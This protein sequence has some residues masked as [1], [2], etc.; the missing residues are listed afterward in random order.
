[1]SQYL[2]SLA[3]MVAL[4]FLTPIAGMASADGFNILTFNWGDAFATGGSAAFAT[5]LVGLVAKLSGDPEKPT[6]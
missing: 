4:A 5:L 3:Q 6:F 1:M 2:R